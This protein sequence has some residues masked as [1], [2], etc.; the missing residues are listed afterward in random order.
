MINRSDNTPS[1]VGQ[2][3]KAAREKA[4][5]TQSEL[6]SKLGYT[7][8]TAVSLIEAGERGVKVE[9]LEK[10]A[11]ILHQDVNYLA[12]GEKVQ[13]SVRTAL[14]ADKSFD[15]EDLK[16]IETFIDYLM[17]QKKKDGRG[18]KKN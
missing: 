11:K 15:R 17:D 2:R 3:I 14:R 18:T 5:L 9:I 1:T 6:A 10:I 16:K 13:T 12:T 4:D 7:S 8:P